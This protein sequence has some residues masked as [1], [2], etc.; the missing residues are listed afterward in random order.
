MLR[1]LVC[2]VANAMRCDMSH[3]EKGPVLFSG[4]F[5]ISDVS[6]EVESFAELWCN[7]MRFLC[8]A[9]LWFGLGRI[10]VELRKASW[11]GRGRGWMKA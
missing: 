5:R 2:F 6:A 3:L 8:S 10:R 1:G 7:S 4:R 9:E 11:C